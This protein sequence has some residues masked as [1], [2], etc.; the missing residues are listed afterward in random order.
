VMM[1][2]VMAMMVIPG[3][4]GRAGKHHQQQDSG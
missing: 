4:K 3:S 1:V 2:M